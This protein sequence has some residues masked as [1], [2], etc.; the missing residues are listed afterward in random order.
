MERNVS[1]E[2]IT[3]GKKYHKNDMVRLGCNDCEGC[4]ACCQGM[5]ESIVLDPWDIHMLSQNLQQSFEDMIGN[6]IELHSEQ[7]MILPHLKLSGKE[8]KCT[9]LNEEGRCLIH[10]FRP[11]FCRLFPLGRLYEKES[12]VYILQ[13]QECHKERRT[14]VKITNI[15]MMIF[16]VNLTADCGQQRNS[17]DLTK[18]D[19]HENTGVFKRKWNDRFC[20]T[21]LWMQHRTL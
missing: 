7:G 16:I 19:R 10:A 2:E 21:F 9:F 1:L 13:T 15:V 8:E 20:C 18:E 14:K 4:S 11:G 17:L 6:S 12:F 5:G 3:D